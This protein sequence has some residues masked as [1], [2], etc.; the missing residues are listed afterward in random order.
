MKFK[1]ILSIAG[2]ACAALSASGQLLPYQNPSLSAEERAA[3][4]CSRLTLEEK[5]RLMIN[6]SPAIERL[7]IPS[8]DWWS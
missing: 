8:F 3:D 7:C 5:S 1:Q 2:L 4:L 6:S